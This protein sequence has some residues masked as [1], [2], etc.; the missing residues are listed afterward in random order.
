[1]VHAIAGRKE[2]A[3]L[4]A[5]PD[6]DWAMWARELELVE[7][8]AGQVVHKAGQEPG[9]VLFPSTAI[10]SLLH[11]TMGGGSAEI[12]A[13]GREGLVGFSV[14]MGGQST[15]SEAVVQHAGK[16]FRLRA[17]TV[18]DTFNAGGPV[19][20]LLLRYTQALI[21]QIGQTAVC[22]RFHSVDHQLC[23]CLLHNLD[24]AP[25][26][27][28]LMTHEFIAHLLGV[29]REG[30][31]QGAL[32]LQ[33]AGLIRYFRGHIA[34]LD[35]VGLQERSCECYAV[36]KHEYERLVPELAAA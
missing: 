28:L 20:L 17:K 30:V 5:L 29:R 23:R 10:V 2:N 1:M 34:V 16:A 32:K 7:L 11:V 21:A 6:A 35:R 27:E 15:S 22:N 33:H 18:R 19:T 31:T 3:L 8:H 24:R 26:N 25:G 14:F 4:A 9:H 13:V 12:A 36:I